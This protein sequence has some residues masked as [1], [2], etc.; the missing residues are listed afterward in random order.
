ME[1]GQFERGLGVG[2][3]LDKAGPVWAL[4]LSWLGATELGCG[5]GQGQRARDA[6]AGRARGQ[7]QGGGWSGGRGGGLEASSPQLNF[8]KSLKSLKTLTFNWAAN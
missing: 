4:G 6:G 5:G 1:L 7:G 2:A 3:G 8:I